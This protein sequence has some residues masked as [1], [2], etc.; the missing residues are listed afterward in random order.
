MYKFEWDEDKN[1]LNIEKHKLSFESAPQLFLKPIPI[2]VD[3]RIDYKE[4]RYIGFG[5]LG[6]RL[7]VVVFTLRK[8][9]IVRLISF[10]KA[11]NREQKEYS[12]N[13]LG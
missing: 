12:K 10:R 7:M 1:Q 11:N 5:E 4:K 3:D 2:I 6:G 9:N 8:N 13:K